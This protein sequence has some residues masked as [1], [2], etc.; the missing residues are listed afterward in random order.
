VRI[1]ALERA[2]QERIAAA[3]RAQEARIAAARARKGTIV[4]VSVGKSRRRGG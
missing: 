4:R 3:R 1:A 2:R